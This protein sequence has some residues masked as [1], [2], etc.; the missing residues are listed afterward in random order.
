M[1]SE[2]FFAKS[3]GQETLGPGTICRILDK[4]RTHQQ[5][6]SMTAEGFGKA[7]GGRKGNLSIFVQN[8]G[9]KLAG[10]LA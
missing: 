3:K 4:N 8:N 6:F 9:C 7:G 2:A 10:F 5:S 1:G